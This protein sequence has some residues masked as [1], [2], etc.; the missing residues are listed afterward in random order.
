LMVL[1][2]R[3]AGWAKWPENGGHVLVLYLAADVS[4]TDR[5]GA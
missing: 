5:D 2:L 1:L 3:V 4:S